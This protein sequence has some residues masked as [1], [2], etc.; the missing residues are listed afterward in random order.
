MVIKLQFWVDP[1]SKMI[2]KSNHF[3]DASKLFYI[4]IADMAIPFDLF[5]RAA[6]K[7][8]KGYYAQT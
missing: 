1:I 5:K 8:K 7:E 3:Q 4:G 6:L 2:Q